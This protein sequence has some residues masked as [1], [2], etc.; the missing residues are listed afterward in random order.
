[1]SNTN[2]AALNPTDSRMNQR[3]QV[4]AMLAMDEGFRNEIVNAL[5]DQSSVEGILKSYGYSA[6]F[7]ANLIAKEKV[8]KN[9]DKLKVSDLDKSYFREFDADGNW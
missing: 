7:A 8:I 2:D 6:D 1:M 3:N 5:S 9:L 4:I